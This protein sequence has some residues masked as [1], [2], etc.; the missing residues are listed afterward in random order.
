MQFERLDLRV[1]LEPGGTRNPPL[2]REAAAKMPAGAERI[3]R[4]QV[5][6]AGALKGPWPMWDVS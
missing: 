2:G 5:E 1:E 6:L 4:G 3:R